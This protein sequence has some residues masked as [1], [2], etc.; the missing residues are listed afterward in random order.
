MP[1]FATP[2][3]AGS[4]VAVIRLTMPVFQQSRL[5]RAGRAEKPPAPIL[6]ASP[7]IEN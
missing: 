6:P 3:L 7:D 5:V 2:A 1:H 4:T